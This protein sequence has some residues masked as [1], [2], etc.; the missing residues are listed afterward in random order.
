MHTFFKPSVRAEQRVVGG[1]GTSPWGGALQASTAGRESSSPTSA[2][3]PCPRSGLRSARPRF[4]EQ[5]ATL[6]DDNPRY[7]PFLVTS[8]TISTRWAAS[9]PARRWATE[10][11]PGWGQES[12]KIRAPSG[13]T[14]STPCRGR[15]DGRKKPFCWKERSAMLDTITYRY[16]GHSPSGDDYRTKE[17]LDA[18]RRGDPIEAYGQYLVRTRSHPQAC[19]NHTMPSGREDAENLGITVDPAISTMVDEAFIESVMFSNGSVEVHT[20]NRLSCRP[21]KRTPGS[22]DRQ[23]QPLCV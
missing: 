4:D 15:C 16:S 18:F 23:A 12:I 22:A 13:S 14:A 8:S 5:Y 1:S 3:V 11:P 10:S 9:P 2:T 6:W 17:E 21:W 19:L 20:A 7:P